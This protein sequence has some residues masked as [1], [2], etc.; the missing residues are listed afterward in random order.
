M[1]SFKSFIHGNDTMDKYA[2]TYNR[3]YDAVLQSKA[4]K[5]GM[6]NGTDVLDPSNNNKLNNMAKNDF[7][8][9]SQI[10]SL[11]ELMTS[12]KGTKDTLCVIGAKYKRTYETLSNT[13]LQNTVKAFQANYQRTI[14]SIGDL[15]KQIEE[16]DI[17]FIKKEIDWWESR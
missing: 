10:K 17:P 3:V 13:M 7:S 9:D 16:I 5:E 2:E 12:L 8:V 11:N 14:K 15:V 1:I 6:K 4:L